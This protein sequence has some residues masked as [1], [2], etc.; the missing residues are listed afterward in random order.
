MGRACASPLHVNLPLPLPAQRDP[1]ADLAEHLRA[2]NVSVSV[3]VHVHVHV[4]Q[5]TPVD[6][7]QCHRIGHVVEDQ[8]DVRGVRGAEAEHC[9]VRQ[10]R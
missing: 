8:L 5:L 1:C 6:H 2:A 3:H 9:A 4:P 10:L 7:L